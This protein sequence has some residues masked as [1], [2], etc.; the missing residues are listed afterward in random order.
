MAVK[1]AV[2]LNFISLWIPTDRNLSRDILRLFKAITDSVN[3]LR[4]TVKEGKF[5]AKVLRRLQNGIRGL[6]RS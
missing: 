2:K 5:E 6:M 1:L 4:L 3:E